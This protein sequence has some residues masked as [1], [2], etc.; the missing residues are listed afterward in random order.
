MSET[1]LLILITILVTVDVSP[2]Q[3]DVFLPEGDGDIY[4]WGTVRLTLTEK[5]LVGFST[6]WLSGFFLFN[7]VPEERALDGKENWLKSVTFSSV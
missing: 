3:L 4:S 5:G 6:Q 7:S 1:L 2:G